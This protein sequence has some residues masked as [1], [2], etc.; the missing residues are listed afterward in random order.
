MICYKRFA[1]SETRIW[2]SDLIKRFDGKSF[3][4]SYLSSIQNKNIRNENDN[5]NGNETE[6]E[7]KKIKMKMKMKRYLQRIIR[8][9][10]I[11]SIRGILIK[12]LH[13]Y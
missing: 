4:I 10:N 6:N 1:L 12:G 3:N 8:R 7:K 9:A 2:C 13:K 5:E 11:L